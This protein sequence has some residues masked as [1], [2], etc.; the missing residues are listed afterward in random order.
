MENYVN[1]PVISNY[2][3]LNQRA[4]KILKSVIITIIMN[5]G[6]SI[7]TREKTIWVKHLFNWEFSEFLLILFCALC[8]IIKHLDIQTNWSEYYSTKLENVKNIYLF[9]ENLHLQYTKIKVTKYVNVKKMH[10]TWSNKWHISGEIL[11]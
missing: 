5:F 7:T 11:N 6:F 3:F 9:I 8:Y 1:W 4:F 2:P 10:K